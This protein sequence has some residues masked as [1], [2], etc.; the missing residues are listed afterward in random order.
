MAVRN[1]KV[2]HTVDCRGMAVRTKKVVQFVH[3]GLWLC[4][5]YIEGGHK[6]VVL[7]ECTQHRGMAVQNNMVIHK[8]M[9]VINKKAVQ[10][11]RWIT[12]SNNKV[13]HRGMA[14]INK[15]VAHRGMAV[16]N[17]KVTIRG[18][19][20]RNKKVVHKDMAVINKKAVQLQSVNPLVPDC[21][22]KYG[23]SKKSCQ[24]FF[25]HNAINSYPI[26]KI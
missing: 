20:V 13:V 15:K 5:M 4:A 26:F 8:D 14:V 7:V 9:A 24:Y 25:S 23:F 22:L 10:L 2:V 18:M 12:V 11:H 19:A 16:R 17:N 1:K 6:K 3:T 21:T